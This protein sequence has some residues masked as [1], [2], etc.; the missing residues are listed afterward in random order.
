MLSR[1]ATSF[2]R[3]SIKATTFDRIHAI[4]K[5]DLTNFGW[6]K[7]KKNF[8]MNKSSYMIK[9]KKLFDKYFP[10][11]EISRGMQTDGSSKA[12][13]KTR[14]L[15]FPS[16]LLLHELTALIPI[17][18]IYLSLGVWLEWMKDGEDSSIRD[19]LEDLSRKFGIKSKH[20]TEQE[21][22]E[23]DEIEKNSAGSEISSHLL[24]LSLSYGIVKLL[25]PLRIGL[26]IWLTPVFS[27]WI[28]RTKFG[29]WIL[30]KYSSLVRNAN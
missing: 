15:Y 17:P 4:K 25:M 14:L 6:K 13:S 24:K 27:R 3:V 28:S 29:D 19:K 26:S 20:I 1:L 22:K 12:A 2:A 7:S 11:T 5:R 16:F 18:F 9:M 30:R 8:N 23:S 10:A 21:T